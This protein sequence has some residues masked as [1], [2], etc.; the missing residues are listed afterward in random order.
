MR[1]DYSGVRA[2]YWVAVLLAGLLAA[3]GASTS[4]ALAAYPSADDFTDWTSVDG[5]PAVATGTLNGSTITLSGTHVFPPPVSVVDGHWTANAGPDFSPPLAKTDV[6]QI[7]ANSPPES[8]TLTFGA[9]VTDPVIEI[10]SLASTLAFPAGTQIT[11]IVGQS[12]F[13]VS[14]ST[15]NGAPDT[16]LG[17][18]GIND[19]NGTIQLSGTFT[20]IS[21]TATTSVAFGQDDGG[22]LQVG[23]TS[24]TRPPP[25]PPPPPPPGG[26]VAPVASF[27]A[28]AKTGSQR[29]AI[30]DARGTTNA[31][32]LLWDVNGDGHT[33]V[34]CGADTPILGLRTLASATRT[35]RLTAIALDGRSSSVAQQ[36]NVT[37]L[38]SKVLKQTPELAICGASPAFVQGS[39]VH[40][41]RPPPCFQPSTVTF[42]V[43][44]AKGCFDHVLNE[45]GVPKPEQ[46]VVDEYYKEAKLPA[47]AQIICARDPTSKACT[48]DVTRFLALDLFVAHQPVT[49]NGLTFSPRAAGSIVLFP[50]LQRIVSSNAVISI[51]RVQVASG[52]I[53]FDLNSRI[54]TLS[55][56]FVGRAP[57]L[58]FDARRDLPSI[59]GFT[60]D[61]QVHL[62]FVQ[63]GAHRYTEATLHLALPPIFDAFGGN[64]P[65]GAVTAIADN[66][67]HG[68]VLDKLHLA[69]PEASLGGLRFTN[70]AFDYDASGDPA[71]DCFGSWWKA[72]ANVFLGTTG[73]DAGFIL[74]PPPSQNGIALCG[75]EFKS[76]GG[77]IRFGAQ[78]P[79]PQLLPGVSLQ[80]IDFDVGLHPTLVRGGVQISV[81][82]IGDVTGTVL[83][84]FP[85]SSEPYVLSPEDAKSPEHPGD[86]GDLAAL[87]GRRL[88][89]PFV[90]AGGSVGVDI[91]VLGRIPFGSGYMLISPDEIALGGH[92]SISVPGMSIDGGLDGDW[93][94]RTGLF[95]LHG[96]IEACVAGLPIFCPRV[97][98]WITNR[99]MVACF[100]DIRHEGWH[101]GAGYYWGDAWPTVWLG[102]PA[103]NCKPS[104][105]WNTAASA[106]RTASAQS[107]TVA[108]GEVLKDVSLRGV[109]GAPNIEIRG[110]DGET[111]SSAT[112]SFVATGR[113]AILR[114]DAG[115]VTWIGVEHGAPGRYTITL[116][117][118]SPPIAGV[119]ATRP[120][121]HTIKASV[122]GN[123]PRRTLRYLI[124]SPVGQRVTFFERGRSVFRRIGNARAGRGVIRFAPAPGPGG[125]RQIVAQIQVDG[126]PAPDR[127]AGSYR[128]PAPFKAVKPSALRATRRGTMLLVSWRREAGATMYGV[129]VNQRSAGERLIRLRA[130]RHSVRIGGIGKSQSGTVA[131]SARGGVLDWGRPSVARFPATQ[132]PFSVLRPFGQLGKPPPKRAS[133]H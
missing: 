68:L 49:I 19:S 76:A 22:I 43:V 95:T 50:G 90:A 107:F 94:F 42:G 1:C 69:V 3:A 130:G 72:T 106:A 103:G 32:K 16:A 93:A 21:F 133:R 40:T 116:L 70:V 60:L 125:V 56:V 34:T 109:G 64:P 39:V 35:V 124:G 41:L 30:L 59:G 87:T 17:P 45:D 61:G 27:T 120:G 63:N 100:G 26:A 62:D 86:P 11:K 114:Q 10:G 99:G 85:S 108:R 36:L 15:V 29:L 65:N 121:S 13:T 81:A 44:E 9:P 57:L 37:G 112:G 115:N 82:D 12:G 111:V 14:G 55:K 89:S 66:T 105:Y 104:H 110:P 74:S 83:L 28:A 84:G 18:D 52:P 75:D 67:T 117:P 20:S 79:P 78:I 102:W 123:G 25:P 119:A 31:S 54:K 8:Y 47:T 53:D 131:V 101:P 113:F 126:V 4:A 127:V 77:A 92:T 46:P 5:T 24:P 33:D 118:G 80:E 71:A 96:S 98:A 91:P 6:I 58:D 48:D 23:A 2:R 129:V 88:T 73:N 97:E 128:A 38:P 122:T 7:G 132:K 51:G